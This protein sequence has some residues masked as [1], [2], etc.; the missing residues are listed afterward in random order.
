MISQA[1]SN[2][3]KENK[4]IPYHKK[5]ADSIIKSLENG[6]A[7]WQ[8]PWDEN[9][10]MPLNSVSGKQYQGIN[11]IVLSCQHRNDP[12]WVTYKQA[13]DLG[14]QVNK[15]E[16]G[17]TIQYWKFENERFKKDKSGKKVLDSAGKPVKIITK[18]NPPAVFYATVFNAE[19][20]TGLP[21]RKEKPISWNPSE[22]AEKLIKS[23]GA[24]LFHDGN[25]RAFYRQKSDTIHLPQ[26]SSFKEPQKYY[27]VALHELGHWTGHKTRLNRDMKGAF[28]SEN[29]AKEEL[30]AEISSMMVGDTLKIGH[31]PS[32]HHAY[33]KS[34]IKALKEDPKEIFRATSDAQKIHNYIMQKEKTTTTNKSESQPLVLTDSQKTQIKRAYNAKLA[35]KS[36]ETRSWLKTNAP[37]R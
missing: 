1:E 19:Q 12:R 23:S 10:T 31:D 22:R 36:L 26:K 7:P 11:S 20:I 4:D 33:I 8:K 6:T 27:A 30:R 34:W 13:K 14:A 9:H 2:K 29:Y 32:Q 35:T 17:T 24:K 5:V 37:E 15:G 3:K 28:G 18:L 21:K 16:H 25:G